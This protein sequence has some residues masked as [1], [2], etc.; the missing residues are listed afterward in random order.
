MA[1]D[2]FKYTVKLKRGDSQDIQKCKVTA[3]TI[4]E[5]EERVDEVRER[6]EKWADDYRAIQ[7]E[8][9]RSVADDHPDFTDFSEGEA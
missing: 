8:A 2:V 5:L 3:E 7:P 9:R 4:D 6:M 1:E